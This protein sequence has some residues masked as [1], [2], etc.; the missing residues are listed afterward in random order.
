LQQDSACPLGEERLPG[1]R[2]I[3]NWRADTWNALYNAAQVKYYAKQQNIA[4][5][6][7][8]IEDN[9]ANVDALTLRREE[10]DEIMKN[11]LKVCARTAI[12]LHAPAAVRKAFEAGDYGDGWTAPRTASACQD[13]RCHQPI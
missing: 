12:R 10:S 1:S 13:G 2:V 11:T 3:E 6:I 9:L 7:T 8:A 5:G 4:A